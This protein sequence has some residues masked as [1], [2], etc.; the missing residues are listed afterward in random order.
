M[1]YSIR[2]FLTFGRDAH[3]KDEFISWIRLSLH[4]LSGMP[5]S[6]TLQVAQHIYDSQY[7]EKEPLGPRVEFGDRDFSWSW[8]GAEELVM[9]DM[10]HWG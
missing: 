10:D 8:E 2:K 3:D 4:E 5:Y 1:L 7:P 9:N 6:D